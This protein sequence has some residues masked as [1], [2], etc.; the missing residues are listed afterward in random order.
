MFSDH[1][2]IAVQ[3]MVYLDRNAYFVSEP[4]EIPTS[5]GNSGNFSSTSSVL[6]DQSVNSY[7]RSFG[8]NY[9]DTVSSI[10]ISCDITSSVSHE[11]ASRSTAL[12]ANSSNTSSSNPTSS[13]PMSTNSLNS[14]SNTISTSNL[15][16]STSNT[17]SVPTPTC[18]TVLDS[19]DVKLNPSRVVV[20]LANV[21]RLKKMMNNSERTQEVL[22]RIEDTLKRQRSDGEWAHK[23]L[24][25]VLETWKIYGF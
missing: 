10:P 19:S 7:H 5:N 8:N 13:L 23:G 11:M 3:D 22:A 24:Y 20:S 17:S 4:T 12:H 1:D 14:T 2:N 18:G 25:A 21:E 16:I 15:S 6:D 9:N